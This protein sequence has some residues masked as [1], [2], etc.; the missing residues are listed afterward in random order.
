MEQGPKALLPHLPL[1]CA[2]LGWGYFESQAFGGGTVDHGEQRDLGIFTTG[3]ALLEQA[4]E[5]HP[6]QSLR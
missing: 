1:T 5:C 2:L 3:K 4:A 6:G